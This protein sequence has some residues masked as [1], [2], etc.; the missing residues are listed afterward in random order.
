MSLSSAPRNIK[1]IKNKR[2]LCDCL[3]QRSLKETQFRLNMFFD[4]I[5]DQVKGKLMKSK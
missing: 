1:V 4:R 3:S 2:S 5:L